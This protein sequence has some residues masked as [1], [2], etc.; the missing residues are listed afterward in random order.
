MSE[1]PGLLA[2]LGVLLVLLALA[3]ARSWAVRVTR[4]R[5]RDW[6]A[7]RTAWF[8]AGL[9]VAAAG[10][11]VGGS[12]DL[13]AEVVAHLLLGVV[14]PLLLVL[15]TPVTLLLR[16]LPAPSARRVT[17]VLGTPA[18]R[19]ATSP[20]TAALL[21]VGGLWLLHTTALHDVVAGSAALTTAVHLHFL[22]SGYLF[23]AGVLGVDPAPHLPSFPR[24]AVVLVL[25][26]AAHAVLAKHVYATPPPGVSA[27]QAQIAGLLLWYGGDAAHLPLL[28]VFCRRWLR[29]ASPVRAATS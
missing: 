5:G 6:P 23:T 20:V 17:R 28:V 16:A 7:R 25:A 21:S 15:G 26:T 27:D 3:A 10:H 12:H 11:V 14:A 24:R 2:H 8:T 4:S 29:R 19:I 1:Q 22:L 13:R 18:A 9:V